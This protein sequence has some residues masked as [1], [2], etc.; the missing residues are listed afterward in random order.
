MSSPH[1]KTC[2]HSG[3]KSMKAPLRR[4]ACIKTFFPKNNR[5]FN[6]ISNRK[7]HAIARPSPP[8]SSASLPIPTPTLRDYV[9]RVQAQEDPFCNWHAISTLW[10]IEQDPETSQLG[11]S[12]L[13]IQARFP[14]TDKAVG[15]L[16]NN[17]FVAVY[18][19]LLLTPTRCEKHKVFS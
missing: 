8:L 9:F 12:G 14:I 3:F 4:L 13:T 5:T 19:S 10:I 15:M 18:S 2:A 16:D 7:G 17:E 11:V 1:S 6:I